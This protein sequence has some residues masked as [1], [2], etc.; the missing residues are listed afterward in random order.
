MSLGILFVLITSCNIN[1]P[2]SELSSPRP[3]LVVCDLSKLGTVQ[4]LATIGQQHS[5]VPILICYCS[6]RMS[7]YWFTSGH[8]GTNWIKYWPIELKPSTHKYAYRYMQAINAMNLNKSTSIPCM[9]RLLNYTHGDTTLISIIEKRHL[10]FNLLYVWSL[11]MT[12]T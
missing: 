9:E 6:T 8:H 3:P 11:Y 1:S 4:N 5:D 7:Q 10:K 12:C 2:I